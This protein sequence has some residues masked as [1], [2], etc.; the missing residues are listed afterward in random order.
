VFRNALIRCSPLCGCSISK[1]TVLHFSKYA[2]NQH[3]HGYEIVSGVRYLWL[4]EAKQRHSSNLLLKKDFKNI[5]YGRHEILYIV[6][7]IR[8]S[9]QLT[10]HKS[11]ARAVRLRKLQLTPW[12]LARTCPQSCQWTWLNTGYHLFAFQT[13]FNHENPRNRRVK[14]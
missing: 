10:V 7:C 5:V 11:E 14:M 13:Q 3:G 8:P 4:T 12:T 2:K 1:A 9:L 6:I